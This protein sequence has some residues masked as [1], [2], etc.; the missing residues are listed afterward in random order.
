MT[1]RRRRNDDWGC[2]NDDWG[3]RNDDWGCRNDGLLP[4]H[5]SPVIPAQAGTTPAGA[6]WTIGAWTIAGSR[7]GRRTPHL[8]SPLKGVSCKMP[9]FGGSADQALSGRHPRAGPRDAILQETPKRGE[10]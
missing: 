2:R 9:N 4:R 7:S 10:G 5:S 6:A 3:C 8:T 1:G